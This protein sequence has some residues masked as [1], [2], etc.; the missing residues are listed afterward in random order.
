VGAIA[1]LAVVGAKAW[2]TVRK[3]FHGTSPL[4]SEPVA[5]R[6]WHGSFG[7]EARDDVVVSADP[8]RPSGWV[9]I[10]C[11]GGIEGVKLVL[12]AF[13]SQGVSVVP[14][15]RILQLAGSSRLRTDARIAL[16]EALTLQ[17]ADILLCQLHGALENALRA[18]ETAFAER[19]LQSASDRL[20]LLARRTRLGRHLTRPW[21]VAIA[22]APNVG[23]SSLMNALAGYQRS[24]VA[25]TA[26]TTRDV[27]STLL[28]FDGWPVSVADTAG[29]R[30][31]QDALESA[32]VDRAR[33]E[34]EHAD[35]C[36]W[37]LDGAAEPCWPET[38]ADKTLFVINKLD[39]P[40]AWDFRQVAEAVGVSARSGQGIPELTVAI[41]RA[42]VPEAPKPGEA[43]P[44]CDSLCDAIEQAWELLQAGRRHEAQRIIHQL[45]A[46]DYQRETLQGA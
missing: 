24:I 30:L 36:L 29:I 4:P 32:G 25:P 14:W 27:I 26:G 6:T 3:L 38:A 9:E 28:A 2:G 45:L 39:L 42:L 23:K 5:D 35:L 43:I 8:E 41:A 44:C 37:V 18:I 31:A 19:A 20:R 22:G 21:R 33:L 16:A 15:R 7:V 40:A 46:G 17:T 34:L 1:T 10:H 11:H 12:E 13:E